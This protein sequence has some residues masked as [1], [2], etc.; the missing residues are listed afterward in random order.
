M[1][2]KTVNRKYRSILICLLCGIIFATGASVKAEYKPIY[3]PTLV[4]PKTDEIIK[5][6]GELDE[7]AWRLAG[8][9]DNFAEHYPG[10]QTEPPVETEA[11]ITYNN[12]NLY[13]AFVC[14][15]DPKI[16]RASFCDRERVHTDDNIALCI[17]TYGDAAWAYVLNV[18]PYGVQADA[19]WSANVGEDG[20]YDM[21]WESAGKVTD[22]GYLIELA[23]PFSSMRFPD[24][25][26]QTWKIDFWRN[27]PRENRRQYSWAAYDR[28]DTCWPCKWGTVTGIK[29]VQ[30]GKGIEF[31]PSV[32]A[33]QSGALTEND[34]PNSPFE[35]ENPDGEFSL[36]A[37]Y[38]ISSNITAEATF[39][40][41]FSQVES[42]AAQIDVNSTFALFYPEKRPFFQEGSDLFSTIFFAVYTRLINNPQLAGKMTGRINRTS[43]AY[44]IARDEDSPLILPAEES[45][46]YFLLGKSTSNIFRIR[47]TFGEDSRIGFL[48]TDR[49][50]DDGASGTLLSFD[51]AFRLSPKNML[52][53]QIICSHTGE[54]DDTSI[55]P[56]LNDVYINDDRY[57]AG[58]DGE[59]FW[60]YAT[61]TGIT[62]NTRNI[63]IDLSFLERSPTY[64]ADNGF[65][66]KNNQRSIRLYSNYTFYIENSLFT[67]ITPGLGLGTEKNFRG[68]KK[69]DFVNLEL[70]GSLQAAQTHT[71]FR[72]Q[73][74]S[75]RLSDIQFNRLWNLHFCFNSRVSE[76]LAFGSAFEYGKRIARRENPPVFG[77]EFG[78]FPWIDIKP[79]D[80]LLIETWFNYVK[81]NHIDTDAELFEE[82]IPRM[83]VSLQITRGL[84]LRLVVQHRNRYI[85]EEQ[86]INHWE[87]DPLVTYRLNPFSIFYIGSTHDY[88]KLIDEENSVRRWESTSR[89]FFMKLQYLFQI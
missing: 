9:A 32:I 39:N 52:H 64:R 60:G 86:T 5:I 21:I 65:Q 82:F 69:E 51:G 41:D 34:N 74:S 6:D 4:V 84:S 70:S 49:R 8:K 25:E 43:F 55:T 16:I 76:L 15:D 23:I 53:W 68:E 40:P 85:H 78:I 2:N 67:R 71:H 79:M 72:Y 31:L 87:I 19:L 35:N 62:H 88:N 58:F 47:Q 37:S 46:D 73:R 29:N 30:S 45:S 7:P 14:Y 10:D 36:G 13:V 77:K 59:S 12:D 28:D 81:S 56:G 38:A 48:I 66:A 18:N 80:R 89:Q 44:M 1:Q 20:G 61:Y 42:D 26:E 11:F 27:H 54:L 63:S 33:Y 17:D 75:E 50:F 57:T 22:S 3:H 83:R 24:K